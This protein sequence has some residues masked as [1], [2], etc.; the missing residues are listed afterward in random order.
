MLNI[1]HTTDLHGHSSILKKLPKP[2]EDV[3]L[4]DSGDAI[5]GSCTVFRFKE[6]IFEEMNLANLSAMTMGNRE[7]SYFPR[8]LE[9]RIK[10]IKFP[11]LSANFHS[12]KDYIHLRDFIVVEKAGFRIGITG[13]SPIQFST[14]L[15][16][17]SIACGYFEDYVK[18]MKAI[19]AKLKEQSDYII[20]LSHSG[21]KE[22]MEIAKECG[23]INLILAGH[24][25][26]KF[27][28][29]VYV[30]DTAVCHT[31]CY[32]SSYALL[33]IDVSSKKILSY[34]NVVP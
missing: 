15:L 30:N 13:L 21:L 3:I 6:P 17:S 4:L 28:E 20:L 33:K 1:V 9:G 16:L 23:F 5:L 32:G 12:T 29:P 25:H 22:D 7:F 8:V 19:E 18:A 34:E 10:A 26:E 27:S 24:S 11:M 31:G 2:S 14:R